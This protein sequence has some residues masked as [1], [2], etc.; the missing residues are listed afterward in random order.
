MYRGKHLVADFEA[1]TIA[2]DGASVRLTRREFELLRYFMRSTHVSESVV[3][4]KL[5]DRGQGFL[6]KTVPTLLEK[7]VLEQIDN[8]GGGNQRR[9]RLSMPLARVNASIAASGGE[10]SKFLEAATAT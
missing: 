8:R 6:D 7:N 9:F 4:M 3:K 10:F 5:G 1:V 2:V